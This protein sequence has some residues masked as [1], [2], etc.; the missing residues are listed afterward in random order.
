MLLYDLF[1]NSDTMSCE[2]SM[3]KRI[4]RTNEEKQTNLKTSLLRYCTRYGRN[5]VL[6]DKFC[7]DLFI[8]TSFSLSY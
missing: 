7:S 1:N 6:N 8:V 2:D 3:D 5:K 4:V